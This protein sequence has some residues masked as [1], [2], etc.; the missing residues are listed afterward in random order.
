MFFKKIPIPSKLFLATQTLSSYKTLSSP[1]AGLLNRVSVLVH[2][3][4]SVGKQ[5]WEKNCYGETAVQLN[6]SSYLSRRPSSVGRA[7]EPLMV[8]VIRNQ[9]LKNAI[10][11][12]LFTVAPTRRITLVAALFPGDRWED[13]W[14]L[15][16]GRGLLRVPLPRHPGQLGGGARQ[17]RVLRGHAY[18]P[19]V[20]MAISK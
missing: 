20:G 16:G 17:G 2:F 13:P 11:R 8:V 18:F 9:T 19:K 4:N 1:A 14:R 7:D 15:P 10:P 12:A 3:F 6:E 5:Q